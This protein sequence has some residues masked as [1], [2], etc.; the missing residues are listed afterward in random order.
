MIK[1]ILKETTRQSKE[2]DN[3]L[4]HPCVVCE[5]EHWIEIQK[6]EQSP[7]FIFKLGENVWAGDDESSFVGGIKYADIER[8]QIHIEYDAYTL[9]VCIVVWN[10]MAIPFQP[11]FKPKVFIHN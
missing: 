2:N 11:M 8:Q 10:K 1:S 7:V 6:D 9:C 5:K 3:S 4:F